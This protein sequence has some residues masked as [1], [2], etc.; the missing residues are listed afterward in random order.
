MDNE[1]SKAL[2]RKTILSYRKLLEK[3]VYY[4]RNT[5]LCQK[6]KDWILSEGVKCI[7]TF[8]PIEQNNEPDIR[9]IVSSL[10][11]C[12]CQFIISRTDFSSKTMEHFYLEEET[13]LELNDLGIPEPVKGKEAD[14]SKV[15]LIL[16]PLLVADQEMNRLGYG[17]GYYD[18]LLKQT[19]AVKVGLSLSPLVNHLIQMEPWDVPLDKVILGLK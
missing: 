14:L 6:L 8:L 17:G 16:V 7:H 9:P 1:I 10:R 4:D 15:D 18:R 5:R 12:G 3:E 2:F 11:E 19:K 13:T